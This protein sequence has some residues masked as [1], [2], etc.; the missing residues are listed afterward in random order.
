MICVR[1]RKL[2]GKLVTRRWNTVHDMFAAFYTEPIGNEIVHLVIEDDKVI[3][4]SL[5]PNDQYFGPCLWMTDLMAWFSDEE[6]KLPWDKKPE[7]IPAQRE[8][9]P[10][11]FTLEEDP[12][13][14]KD[15]PDGFESFWLYGLQANRPLAELLGGQFGQLDPNAHVYICAVVRVGYDMIDSHLKVDVFHPTTGVTEY[16][17]LLNEREK[18]ILLAM[19]QK[20]EAERIH[21]LYQ[22]TAKVLEGGLA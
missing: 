22:V 13:E 18:A 17:R 5:G 1:S 10:A 16:S 14:W 21:K 4:S 2:Q 11:D 20:Y 12:A 9:Q 3:Y 7:E 6:N 8:F 15:M 19:I